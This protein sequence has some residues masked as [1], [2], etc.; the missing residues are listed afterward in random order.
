MYRKDNISA[1]TKSRESKVKCFERNVPC[2][3]ILFYI[4]KGFML[5]RQLITLL[6]LLYKINEH[7]ANDMI[8]DLLCYGLL[9]KKQATDTKT[10]VYVMTK[11][12]LSIYHN[13]S[14]RDSCSIKLNNRKIWSNIYRCEFIIR[15]VVPDME[16]LDLL[17]SLDNLFSYLYTYNISIFSCENQ[18]SVYDLY[19]QLNAIFPIKDKDDIENGRPKESY[20]YNDMWKC[21]AELFNHHTYFLNYDYSKSSKEV[22]DDMQICLKKKKQIEDEKE[23]FQSPK[24]QKMNYYNLFNMVS[25]GFFFMGLPDTGY[26]EVGIF[27]KCNNMYLKKIYENIICIFYMLERYLGYYPHVKLNVYLSDDENLSSLKAK[28]YER[29]FDYNT[30]EPSGLNKRN[31]FFKN[32]GVPKQYW[33]YIEVN[34]IYYPLREKY[35][36]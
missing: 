3:N 8:S 14:S 18:A 19:A 4:G 28:E 12:P 20:F 33:E 17:I 13:C 31:T 2:L 16:R 25:N 6:R 34:Y 26:I 23:M 21:K 7:K 35:N 5:R 32:Y 29:G 10:C 15:K 22:W 36:L 30:Q 24:Y 9:I 1:R 27:D 11:F